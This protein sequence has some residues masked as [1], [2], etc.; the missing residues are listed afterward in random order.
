MGNMLP[1]L[2][3]V[4]AFRGD[5]TVPSEVAHDKVVHLSMEDTAVDNTT[6]PL[7]IHQSLQDSSVQKGS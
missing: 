6:N 5:I 7:V 4:Y 2:R 1:V 3:W